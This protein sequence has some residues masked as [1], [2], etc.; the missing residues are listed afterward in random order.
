MNNLLQKY[1]VSIPR[2]TSYPPVPFWQET[3]SFSK[4]FDHLKSHDDTID[5]YIHVPYCESLCYYCGCNRT[6]TKDHSVENVF[7]PTP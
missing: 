1:N 6:I 2:Y 7:L 3:P 4:W 5:I